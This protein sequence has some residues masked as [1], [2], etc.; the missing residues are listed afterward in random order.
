MTRLLLA[1]ALLLAPHGAAAETA[2]KTGNE[3]WQICNADR[4]QCLSYIIG[5]VDGWSMRRGC[6]PEGVTAEQITDIVVQWLA[7]S[8]HYRHHPAPTLIML[9]ILEAFPQKC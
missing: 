9:A 3:L 8:P 4:P 2:Y 7:R 5:V 1:L 6:L